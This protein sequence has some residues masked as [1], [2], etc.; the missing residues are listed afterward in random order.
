M[1]VLQARVHHLETQLD[2][3]NSEPWRFGIYRQGLAVAWEIAVGGGGL[4]FNGLC[5]LERK[6]W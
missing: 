4:N 2:E 5:W 3:L 6:G 1:K